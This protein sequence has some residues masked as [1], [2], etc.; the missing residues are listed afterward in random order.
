M[1]KHKLSRLIAGT[2]TLLGVL[3]VA[4]AFAASITL[5][6]TLRDFTPATHADFE[7]GR[8]GVDLGIVQSTL[9]PDGKPVY[10]S[11][12]TNLTISDAA[13]F[14]QFYNDTSGVN[15][16]VASS[17]TLDETFAGSGIYRFSSNA[18]FPL[19]GQGFNVGVPGNNYHFTTEIHTLFTYA[20]GQSFTFTG[21]DDVW[22]FI[23]NQLVID[24]GG[25]HGPMSGTVNLNTLGLTVGN[26]YKLDVFHAERQTTGSNF[27]MET[28]GLV[29]RSAPVPEPGT[30]ALVGLGLLAA[31]LRH[32]RAG[33]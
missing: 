1:H 22:V 32:R 7:S 21:D 29:L 33:A 5:A 2:L 25:V 23:N 6:T 31:G 20:T 27:T 14:N 18:Y 8:G 26:D 15:I 30:L 4:P 9:G 16:T 24:L 3:A 11:A 19:N 13:R 28:S 10:N 17:I 12:D